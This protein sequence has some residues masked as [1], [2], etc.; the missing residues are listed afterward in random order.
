MYAMVKRRRRLTREGI[1][2]AALELVAREGLDAL[3]M[4]ALAADL[5]AAPMALYTHVRT[6]DELLGGVL[7]RILGSL[8]F[9]PDPSR[10]WTDDLADLARA[11]HAVLLAHPEA[12]P[13][14]V[15]NPNPGLGAT[16]IGEL[17]LEVLRRGGLEG[18]A[19]VSAFTTLVAYNYGFASFEAAARRPGALDPRRLRAELESLPEEDFPLTVGAAAAMAGYASAARYEAG[20][21]RLIAGLSPRP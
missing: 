6:K 16:R 17:A 20:L 19:A 7:D 13:A 2:D 3:T 9:T 18:A 10:P 14:L 21:E 4:R 15:T 5:G 12:V 11:H 8:A 1:L